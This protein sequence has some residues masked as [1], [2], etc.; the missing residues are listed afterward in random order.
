MSASAKAGSVSAEPMVID[1]KRQTLKFFLL[2]VGASSLYIIVSDILGHLFTAESLEYIWL[3]ITKGLLYVLFIGLL[4]AWAAYRLLSKYRDMERD[5]RQ[6]QERLMQIERQSTAAMC[7]LTLAHD[8]RNLL[9]IQNLLVD[10][11]EQ[12]ESVPAHL[13]GSIEDIK[14]FNHR[15]KVMTDRISASVRPAGP[16]TRQLQDINELLGENLA[17]LRKHQDVSGCTL[18]RQADGPL[19]AQVAADLFHDMMTN[20]IINAAQ[21]TGAGGTIRILTSAT[22]E[23]ITVEVHDDGPGIAADDHDKVFVPCYTT[24]A[25]GTG[26]GLLSVRQFIDAHHGKVAIGDSPLGGALFR[27]SFPVQDAAPSSRTEKI[28][29]ITQRTPVLPGY[30]KLE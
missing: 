9:T 12:Q 6:S 18:D 25:S 27:I 16:S 2:F 1:P 29:R 13:A 17:L 28:H 23:T 10:A 5:L 11:L 7:S 15:L 20:V 24:K 14:A 8:L 19:E 22:A 26:I 4:A 30:S 21:A 3:D